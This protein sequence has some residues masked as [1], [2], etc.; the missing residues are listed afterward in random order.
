MYIDGRGFEIFGHFV[1][2]Y[3]VIISI[4]MVFGVLLGYKLI[5]KRGFK[6]ETIIDLALVCIP[7][8]IVGARLYYCIFYT[9]NYSFI[10][11]FKIW[12]GGLAIYGG[13]IGGA[14]GLIIYCLVKKINFF[15]LADCIV[16][17][18]ILGQA[19]GRWGNFANQEAYGSLIT[20]PSLQFFPFGVLIDSSCYTDVARDAVLNAFGT[21][22]PNAWFMATFFYES[23]WNLLV[24]GA[25]L[26]IFNK[27]K[28]KGL[29]TCGYFVLY[30]LGRLWIEGLRM[31]SLYFLGLRVSQWLSL[32]LI[33]SFGAYAVYLIVQARKRGEP[34]FETNKKCAVANTQN[35]DCANGNA[36][37]SELVEDAE[38]NTNNYNINQNDASKKAESSQE[39]STESYDNKE[40]SDK[41]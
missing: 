32:L 21:V 28:V 9:H 15:R 20:N 35:G 34:I 26:L 14:I 3:G 7:S 29:T 27:T 22:T 13:V 23:M 10:E 1:N 2:W 5:Q 4:G 40:N 25:L 36:N 12:E 16:P 37:N 38:N 19:I 6:G 17:C 33:I 18:L 39:N 30:G 11:F 8:A 24:L 31:D 41:K